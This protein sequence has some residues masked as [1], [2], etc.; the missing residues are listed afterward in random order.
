M[1]PRSYSEAGKI[2]PIFPARDLPPKE[3]HVDLPDRS[4]LLMSLIVAPDEQTGAD[5]VAANP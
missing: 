2:S 1:G 5:V 3:H 4:L